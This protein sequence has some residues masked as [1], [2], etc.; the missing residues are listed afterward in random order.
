[1]GDVSQVGGEWARWR[2]MSPVRGGWW[3]E[4]DGVSELVWAQCGWVRRIYKYIHLLCVWGRKAGE[5][6]V[7]G[8]WTIVTG[9]NLP[10]HKILNTPLGWIDMDSR[11]IHMNLLCGSGHRSSPAPQL[12]LREDDLDPLVA[13]PP[14]DVSTLGLLRVWLGV[15]RRAETPVTPELTDEL[16]FTFVVIIVDPLH[17]IVVVIFIVVVI[18]V[19]I[20][21]MQISILEGSR[22]WVKI[23]KHPIYYIGTVIYCGIVKNLARGIV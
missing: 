15:Q 2:W 5:L 8:G 4:P 12:E 23:L 16:V 13:L 6:V 18:I 21:V 10:P 11:L 20:F 9:E 14:E 19:A 22:N 17:Y 1:M 7:A 3:G